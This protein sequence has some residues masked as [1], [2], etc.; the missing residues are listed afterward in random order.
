[1]HFSTIFRNEIQQIIEPKWYAY[2]NNTK[3]K[4]KVKQTKLLTDLRFGSNLKIF[5]VSAYR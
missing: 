5:G 1:M 3:L 4:I 2:K